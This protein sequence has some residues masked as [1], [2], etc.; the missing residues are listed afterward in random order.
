MKVREERVLADRKLA[1]GGGQVDELLAACWVETLDPGPCA[2]ADGAKLDLG[3][4]LQGDH[5]RRSR[6]DPPGGGEWISATIAREVGRLPRGNQAA[7]APMIARR[8]LTSRQAQRLV[9]QLVAACDPRTRAAILTAAETA[10]PP[11]AR[12][13]AATAVRRSSS[14]P[15]DLMLAD[16]HGVAWRAS[17]LHGERHRHPLAS[18]GPAAMVEVVRARLGE[19]HRVIAPLA[20]TLRQVAALPTTSTRREVDDVA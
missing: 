3:Q 16:A 4:V 17:R 18:L 2:L 6:S 7:A 20:E 11:A 14:T 13:G 12:D 5:R 1:K 15:A 8:G 9:D 19:L 10:P